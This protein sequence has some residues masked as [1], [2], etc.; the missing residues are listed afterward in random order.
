MVRIDMKLGP[1]TVLSDIFCYAS[2]LYL[3]R[4]K[5]LLRNALCTAGVM[6]YSK[7]GLDPLFS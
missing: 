6:W 5:R 7:V 1:H 2:P 4:M 3:C